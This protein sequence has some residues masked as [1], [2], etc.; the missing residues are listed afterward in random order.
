MKTGVYGVYFM[1]I[2][3]VVYLGFSRR[4]I[5]IGDL[6]E[7]DYRSFP[8][9]LL[10]FIK[11]LNGVAYVGVFLAVVYFSVMKYMGWMK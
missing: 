1:M 6:S 10:R 9:G 5:Q 7:E 2:A 8:R 11:I 3:V 4:S